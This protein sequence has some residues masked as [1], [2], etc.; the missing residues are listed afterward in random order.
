MHI[1]RQDDEVKAVVYCADMPA[2][3]QQNIQRLTLVMLMVLSVAA[4][5]S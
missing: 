3:E 1:Y 5:L 2:A 4:V